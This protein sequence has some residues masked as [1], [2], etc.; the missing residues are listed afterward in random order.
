M[1]FSQEIKTAICCESIKSKCCKKS[2]LYGVL[3]ARGRLEAD[4]VEIRVSS[5][6]TLSFISSLIFDVYGKTTQTLP[7]TGRNYRLSFSSSGASRFLES[8]EDGDIEPVMTFKCSTCK[9][10]L[11]QGIFLV[12]GR[13]S[14]PTKQYALEFSADDR[15]DLIEQVLWE[16][17]LHPTRADRRKERLLLI[18]DADSLEDFF[19]LLGI[20][21]FY[22]HIT[23]ARIQNDLR[24]MAQRDSNCDTMNIER[25][26]SASMKQVDMIKRLQEA[27]LLSQ[28]SS[29]LYETAIARLTYS[30]LSLSA[31]AAIM[32]PPIKKS[33]LAH[34]LKKIMEIGKKLL[35]EA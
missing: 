15:V 35:E 10:K 24:A 26:V 33:C 32:D 7:G 34:R 27:G 6:D 31:L 18:K 20:N 21:R 12:C 13:V 11:L 28:L 22:F 2:L 23:D 5:K 29:E 30:D 1:S 16:Y 19:A 17:E 14:D 9:N 3:L 4:R 8:I 25:T